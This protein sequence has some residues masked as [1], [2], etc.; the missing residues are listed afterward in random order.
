MLT[1]QIAA[2]VNQRE[3]A[4]TLAHALLVIGL[5]QGTRVQCSIQ[6]LRTVEQLTE[7]LQ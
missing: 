3:P 4:Q 5:K 1:S 7:E 2:F 6:S